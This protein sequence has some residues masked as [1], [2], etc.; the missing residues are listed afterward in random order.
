MGANVSNHPDRQQEL[1]GFGVGFLEADDAVM[2][3]YPRQLTRFTLDFPRHAAFIKEGFDSR[4]NCSCAGASIHPI[5]AKRAVNVLRIDARL[6]DGSDRQAFLLS[7]RQTAAHCSVPVE[8]RGVELPIALLDAPS[9]LVPGNRGADVVRASPFACGS[10]FLLR[11]A[12][13]QGKN[14]IAQAR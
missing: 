3:R 7:W 13:C 11:F 12:G 5:E 9:P 10:N 1:A 4:P 2:Q 8:L 14:L 6:P